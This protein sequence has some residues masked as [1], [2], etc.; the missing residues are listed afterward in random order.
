MAVAGL[1]GLTESYVGLEGSFYDLDSTRHNLAPRNQSA[2]IAIDDTEASLH[3]V[4]TIRH[5]YPDAKV[6]ALAPGDSR[7][8]VVGRHRRPKYRWHTER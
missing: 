7:K 1:Q 4:R 3:T 6:F 2:V 5:L 8:V